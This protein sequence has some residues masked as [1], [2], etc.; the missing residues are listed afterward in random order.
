MKIGSEKLEKRKPE[1]EIHWN[2]NY[3]KKREK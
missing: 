3:D 1:E 2:K